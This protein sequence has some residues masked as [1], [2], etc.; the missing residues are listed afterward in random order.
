MIPE[1]DRYHGVVLRQ[2]IVASHSPAVIGIANLS[3]RL[4]AYCIDKAAF[5]IKHSTKRLSPWQ[6]TFFPEHISEVERLAKDYRPVWIFLV[7][8]V[9][10]V[11]GISATELR[12]IVGNALVPSA[13][14]VSRDRKSMY[15][16]VGSAGAIGSAI[17][18]GVSNFLDAIADGG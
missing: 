16:V 15:R 8:G 10:G 17:K 18:R 4:D 3:G 11:V 7:C 2:L 9:D 6:F 14:R 13:V 12:A 1:I 5:Y